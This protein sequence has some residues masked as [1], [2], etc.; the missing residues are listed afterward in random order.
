MASS[1]SLAQSKWENRIRT[2]K[3]INGMRKRVEKG[4]WGGMPPRGYKVFVLEDGTK[5]LR[6]T[7]D[8]EWLSEAFKKRS[9]GMTAEAVRHWLASNGIMVS[10]S[11]MDEIFK[12]VF[13]TGY[14]SSRLLPGLLIEGKHPPI[15]D[16]DTF[17]AINSRVKKWGFNTK[18]KNIR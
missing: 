7:R 13:Y 10:R 12:N 17:L 5:E 14:I 8:G 18:K 4:L 9:D 1:V 3:I 11:R 6:I 15:V 16:V 2:E